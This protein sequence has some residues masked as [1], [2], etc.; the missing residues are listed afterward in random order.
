MTRS[1]PSH[2]DHGGGPDTPPPRII[3]AVVLGLDVSG[4]LVCVLTLTILFAGLL[5]NVVLRYFF[6][7]G[8]QWAYEMHAI[9]LPWMVAGGLILATVRN[10]NIAV[11]ILPDLLGP[12]AGRLVTLAVLALTLVISAFVIWSSVPIMRAAQFQRIS[13]LGGISQLWGYASL[14][15][16]FAG[17]AVICACDILTLLMG[18]LP[19][20]GVAASSLS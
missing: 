4:R 18:R 19:G 15:Y 1:G 10:R 9:L 20:R 12:A 3:H 6:G 7:A 2:T 11:T 5:A 17:V 8:L 16:G 13:S 14:V